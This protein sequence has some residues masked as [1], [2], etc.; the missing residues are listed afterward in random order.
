MS[1]IIVGYLNT[2]LSI[3]DMTNRQSQQGF[4]T[5]QDPMNTYK[6]LHPIKAEYMF[7]SSTHR[8]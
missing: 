6:A 4:R 7:F 5:Q 3:T 1:V 2:I 8:K